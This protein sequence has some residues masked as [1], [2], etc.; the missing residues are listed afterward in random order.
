MA[1]ILLSV[2][3]TLIS[4]AVAIAFGWVTLTQP[5]YLWVGAVTF[6]VSVY[7]TGLGVMKTKRAYRS[8]QQRL[9]LP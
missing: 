1:N 2:S 3:L 7:V 9:R 5:A 4:A 8:W 6:T